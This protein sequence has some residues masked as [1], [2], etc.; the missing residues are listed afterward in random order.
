MRKI[1]FLF[2]AIFTCLISFAQD[3][4]VEAG[5]PRTVAVGES[6]RVEFNVSGSK[7][8]EG[9]KAPSFDGFQVIAG[10]SVAHGSQTSIIN[11]VTTSKITNTYTYVLVAE[12]EGNFTIGTASVTV[13]NK[14]YK[15]SSLPIEVVKAGSEI[16]NEAGATRKTLAKDDVL[17]IMEVSNLSPYKGEAVLA[18]LKIYTRVDIVGIEGMKA[19]SFAGF[20]QQEMVGSNRITWS[21]ES[22]NDKIYEVGLIKE[23]L[24]FPQQDGDI[25]IDP[26]TLNLV[27][28]LADNSASS[29]NSMF[30]SFFGN[31]GFRDI[32]KIVSTEAKTIKIKPYPTSSPVSFSGAV[33][34]FQ[35][36]TELSNDM[37]TA[38]SASNLI[39]KISGVGN[40]QLISEP[41]VKLPASFELYKVT[42]EENTNVTNS[43]VMG[44]KIFTYPFIARAKGAYAIEPLSFTYFNPKSGKFVTIKSDQYNIN[45]AAD[46]TS[47][48]SSNMGNVIATTNRENLKIIGSDINHIMTSSAPFKDKESSLIGSAIYFIIMLIIIGIAVGAVVIMRKLEEESKNEVRVKSR[49]ANKVALKQLREVKEYLDKNEKSLFYEGV[50]RAMWGYVADKLNID[51]A[52]LSREVVVSKLQHKGV[53]ETEIESF[54]TIISSCEEAQYA[55]QAS[56]MMTDVYNKA[57]D[58]ITELENK[59]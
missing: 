51:K 34:D 53:T 10:P 28:R 39:V 37:I 3:F 21:R 7:Q 54:M 41:K 56:S 35:L 30:D 32:R 22:Y 42:T 5:A 19:P 4:S 48:A 38:N 50:L 20:W 47:T 25:T 45:V 13:D 2:I 26:T 31:S 36:T 17:L 55:P 46:T 40:L 59:L 15:S 8:A 18:K 44:D 23:Y 12:K 16:R 49:R 9:F 24:L 57:I 11:G 52:S 1:F 29:G 58:V 14:E 33:G 43:G 6:F 27:V